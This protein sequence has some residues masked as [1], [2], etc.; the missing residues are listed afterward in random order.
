MSKRIV[1]RKKH[2]EQY[3]RNKLQKSV[4]A[5]CMSV[6]EFTGSAETTAERVC[7]HVEDWLD[8]KLEVTSHDLRVTTTRFLAQYN[9]PAA[10]VYA[11]HMNIN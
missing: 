9:P 7:N 1:K 5:V 2:T 8:H 10:V 4:H 3:N 6:H 11:T